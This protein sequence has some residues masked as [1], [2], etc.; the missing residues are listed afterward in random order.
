MDVLDLRGVAALTHLSYETARTYRK[1]GRLP[2]P[3]L[4]LGQSPGWYRPTIERWWFGSAAAAEVADPEP[5][6]IA[7][8]VGVGNGLHRHMVPMCDGV[9]G[10]APLYDVLHVRACA[11]GRQRN[12]QERRGHDRRSSWTPAESAS[13][14]G[15]LAD[16]AAARNHL[17]TLF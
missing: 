9:E 13:H 1:N 15:V 7:D 12:Q 8:V 10:V 5:L 14:T 11:H 3:D 2:A 4:T 6:R 16:L 17:G